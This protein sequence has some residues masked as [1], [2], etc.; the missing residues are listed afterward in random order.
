MMGASTNKNEFNGKI[1]EGIFDTFEEARVC[2]EHEN[3]VWNGNIW[4]QKQIISLTNV[5]KKYNN[6]LNISELAQ[7]YDYQLPV[8]I[9]SLWEED[10][11][12]RILDFGGGLGSTYLYVKSL[13]NPQQELI[14]TIVENEE[15][16]KAGKEFYRNDSKI[17][18]LHDL[19]KSEFFDIIHLGSSM[20]YV[21]D[22]LSLLEKFK[23]MKPRYLLFSDLPAA[24]IKSFVTLQNFAGNKIPVRFWNINEFVSSTSDLGFKLILKSRFVN[25]YIDSFQSFHKN[26][27][28]NYFSQLIFR[29]TEQK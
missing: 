18:F 26:H 6:G 16:C 9:S 14:Y 13:L 27:R 10:K 17:R 5:H 8:L 2:I 25:K 28:L 12:L 24:D 4:L 29:N 19:P 1:W 21:D 22:W 3:N 15:I 20:H 7:S 11:S 23:K